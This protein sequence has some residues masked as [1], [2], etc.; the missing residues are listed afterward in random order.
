MSEERVSLEFL[1][2][3]IRDMQ[4]DVRAV[5]TEMAEF[6]DQLT[7]QTAILLRLETGQ[8][9]MAEQLRAIVSQHQRAD[10]RPLA[11]DERLRVLE[12]DRR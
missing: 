11:M 3:L 6:R 12:E 1:A 10:R 5:Q 9:S 8:N 4:S 7:V 2:R